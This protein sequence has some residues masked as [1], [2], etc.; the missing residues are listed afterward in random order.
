M[1]MFDD[2]VHDIDCPHCGQTI[3]K[4]QGKDG[5]CKLLTFK[6]GNMLFDQ[7]HERVMEGV[8]ELHQIH[9]AITS[10]HWVEGLAIVHEG[11]WVA[12]II[13]RVSSIGVG[14]AGDLWNIR[15]E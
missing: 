13:T 4:F 10:P 8:L 12:T 7:D 5:P 14:S 15:H 1:G 9:S 3:T 11:R 6:I 2:Y